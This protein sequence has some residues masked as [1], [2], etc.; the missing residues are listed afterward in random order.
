MKGIVFEKDTNG[1]NRF[2]RFDLRQYGEQL[3]PLLQEL[4]FEQVSDSWE[5]GLTSKEFLTA[6]KEIPRK[7][8]DGRSKVS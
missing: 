8:F 2:V 4:G 1:K 5:E 7:K 3:R 6:A